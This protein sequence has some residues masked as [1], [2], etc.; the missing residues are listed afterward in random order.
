MWKVD[1]HIL[2]P[3]YD[4]SHSFVP[5]AKHYHVTY[6]EDDKPFKNT[7]QKCNGFSTCLDRSGELLYIIILH[8]GRS[9]FGLYPGELYPEIFYFQWPVRTKI[10]LIYQ[11]V[12]K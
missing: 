3:K 7:C 4:I 9:T 2:T 8:A 6:E 12:L 10:Q 5:L 1:Q 11:R